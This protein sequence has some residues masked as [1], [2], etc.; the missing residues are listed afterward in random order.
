MA[1]INGVF[2]APIPGQ[3]LTQPVGASRVEQPP[4]FVH[5]DEAL[6]YTWD[7]LHKPKTLLK[8]IGLVHAGT[9]VEA[10][11]STALFKG[12][13]EGLWT[14]DLSLLMYQVVLWQIES[15]LKLKKIK[16]QT[17]NQDRE[18]DNSMLAIGNL[19]NAKQ[20]KDMT[21]EDAQSPTAQ[22]QADKNQ[23]PFK[24]FF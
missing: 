12:I 3:S 17:F 16:Y 18:H 20:V 9:P 23:K 10:L 2:D 8:L 14:V 13:S 7:R 22:I 24:G 4:K 6:N 15:V 11:V 19:I 5:L 21:F 1:N